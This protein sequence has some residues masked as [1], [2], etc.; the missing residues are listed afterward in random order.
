MLEKLN[1]DLHQPYG[2]RYASHPLVLDV[3]ISLVYWKGLISGVILS[4]VVH[5]NPLCEVMEAQVEDFV[6]WVQK[7]VGRGCH[8]CI[9][10]FI[11]R[12]IHFMSNTCA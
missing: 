4:V 2:I 7:S 11:N 8:Y 9:F 6:S 1:G 3:F 12:N 5:L 10:V